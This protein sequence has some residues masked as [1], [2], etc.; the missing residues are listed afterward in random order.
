MK[1]NPRGIWKRRRKVKELSKDV[2]LLRGLIGYAAFEAVA[3]L[4][5]EGHV[6]SVAAAVGKRYE[7]IK[8]D[9][10]ERKKKE[11]ASLKK[12][13]FTDEDVKRA[14]RD[15]KA[16]GETLS[17]RRIHRN[18]RRLKNGRVLVE[19]RQSR[20]TWVKSERR[21]VWRQEKREDIVTEAEK[22]RL[23][24]SERYYK[25]VTQM[26]ATLGVTQKEAG[27][28]LR[29]VRLQSARRIQKIKASKWFKILKKEH[30]KR[31]RAYTIKREQTTNEILLFR[32]LGVESPTIREFY[33][34][35]N[36]EG[37]TE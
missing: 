37:E 16:S 25:K 8:K 27:R 22:K 17:S 18:F 13:G 19:T 26:A 29:V 12:L 4:Y 33:N 35:E 5:G 14:R 20:R 34:Y 24:S 6:R 32:L 9:R 31:A 30:P 7:K 3:D 36:F 28:V 10:A 1:Q 2:K 23:F 11:V 21:F 15:I